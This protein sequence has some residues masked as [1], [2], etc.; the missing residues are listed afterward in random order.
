MKM[1]IGR[2]I[3]ET[4]ESVTLRIL[5]EISA[6]RDDLRRVHADI[7]CLKDQASQGDIVTTIDNQEL[8]TY[9][10]IETERQT[11]MNGEVKQPEKP[12][13]ENKESAHIQSSGP[14]STAKENPDKSGVLPSH[15]Q[16]DKVFYCGRR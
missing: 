11:Q 15:L 16:I 4:D 9:P 6:L 2:T 7:A 8:K 10:A 3:V 12:A 5:S 13:V 1:E 14:Q